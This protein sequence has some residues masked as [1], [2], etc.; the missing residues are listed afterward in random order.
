MSRWPGNVQKNARNWGNLTELDLLLQK[1]NSDF[2]PHGMWLAY[3]YGRSLKHSATTPPNWIC[4]AYGDPGKFLLLPPP[5]P[6]LVGLRR[7]RKIGPPQKKK[8]WLRRCV[9]V[10]LTFC[11]MHMWLVKEESL[12]R[13]SVAQSICFEPIPVPCRAYWCMAWKLGIKWRTCHAI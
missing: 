13:R 6:N 1:K 4:Q 7:S 12:H 10:R 2:P 3:G 8:S 9:D 11:S 5:P